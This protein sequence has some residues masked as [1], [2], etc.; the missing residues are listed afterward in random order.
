MT[1][2]KHEEDCK[3]RNNECSGYELN[4]VKTIKATHLLGGKC[5]ELLTN[6]IENCSSTDGR[7]RPSSC[8]VY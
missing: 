2:K 4:I 3:T 1:M 7:N 6:V 5:Y 8:R